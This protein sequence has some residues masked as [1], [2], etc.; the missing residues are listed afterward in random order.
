MT[1]IADMEREIFDLDLPAY[2]SLYH[3]KDLHQETQIP[4]VEDFCIGS[5]SARQFWHGER[6]RAKI[7]R[8]PCRFL[9]CRLCKRNEL[10][11]AEYY[12]R[13]FICGLYYLRGSS[14]DDC[15]ST[16]RQ[17]S[18]SPNISSAD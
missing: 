12:S 9:F 16:S 8:G 6:S 4:L 18:A 14:R 1:Q 2:G 10:T 15:Y 3:R 5:V 7:D 13:A 11:V 17:S